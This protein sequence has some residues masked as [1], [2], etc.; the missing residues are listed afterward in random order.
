MK[1]L[2]VHRRVGLVVVVT[3]VS[4]LALLGACGNSTLNAAA[5]R[6]VDFTAADGVSLR[7]HVFGTGQ[8]GIVLAHMYPA[9]QTSWFDT[10]QELAAKGYLVL[11]FDFRGYGESSGSKQ[12]EL[13]GR[14]VEA[15]IAQIRSLGAASVGLVGASMG[16]T[17]SLVAAAEVPVDAVATLSAPVEFQ[18]LSASQAVAGVVAPKLFL[19]EEKDVGATGAEQLDDLAMPPKEMEI[20]PGSDHGTDM[21]AGS[22][23]EAVRARLFDFLLR[24]LPPS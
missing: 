21:L 13:I 6:T 22:S 9:D 19:A 17:A 8:V 10:A 14:D 23:G 16:G 24:N 1:S 12:I 18:G 2:P 7:G 5:A 20:F 11:T 3:A 15:A 4:L